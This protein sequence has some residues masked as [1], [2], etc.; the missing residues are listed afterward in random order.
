MN[1]IKFDYNGKEYRLPMEA[2]DDNYTHVSIPG[3]P[4]LRL[5]DWLESNPPQPVL[6]FVEN[7]DLSQAKIINAVC[8]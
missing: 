4:T 3:G 6:E 7:E 2:Y 5:D 1:S 8:D